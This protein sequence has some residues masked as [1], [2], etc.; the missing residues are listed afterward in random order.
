[1]LVMNKAAQIVKYHVSYEGHFAGRTP[2]YM[3]SSG[4]KFSCGAH[5]IN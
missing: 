5:Y 2:I 1:M 3:E 4:Y